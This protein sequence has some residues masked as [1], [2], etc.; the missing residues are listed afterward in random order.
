VFKSGY[1][2]RSAAANAEDLR[3]IK[4]CTDAAVDCALSGVGGVIGQDEDADDVLRAIEFDRIRGGKPFD[5]DQPWFTDLLADI[6]QPKG[7]NI[8]G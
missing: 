7:A 8:S 2:A 1:F 6:G 4:T 5:I 3:L